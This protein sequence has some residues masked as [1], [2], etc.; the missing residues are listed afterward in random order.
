M[1]RQNV[2]QTEKESS[3]ERSEEIVEHRGVRNEQWYGAGGLITCEAVVEGLIAGFW[4]EM[5]WTGPLPPL[6]QAVQEMTAGSC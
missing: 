5:E 4:Q 1:V 3:E 6:P 2:G